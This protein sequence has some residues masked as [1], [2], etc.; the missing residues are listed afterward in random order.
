MIGRGQGEWVVDTSIH[1]LQGASLAPTAMLELAVCLAVMGIMI[2][3]GVRS[4]VRAE[5]HLRILEAVFFMA[6]PKYAMMEYRAVHGVWPASNDAAAYD[7]R[8]ANYARL[9]SVTIRPGGAADFVFSNRIPALANKRLTIRAGQASAASNLPSVWLCGHADAMP[10]VTASDDRT[11]I[12]DDE[13]PSPC[14]ARR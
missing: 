6:A 8:L 11:T 2:A 1:R 10:P 14:R 13:L 7:L 5:Q 9:S 3:V 12:K 4:L